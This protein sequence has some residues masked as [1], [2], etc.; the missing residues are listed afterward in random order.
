M[1][2]DAMEKNEKAMPNG[3][4]L[5]VLKKHFGMCF[6]R[7]GSLDLEKLK[8]RLGNQVAI[9]NEGYELKFLGKNYAR[10]LTSLETETVV[11]PDKK[12]NAKPENAKSKNVYISGDNLDALKHLLKSKQG[13]VKCI[14]IDPPYNTGSD[15]FVYNDSFGFKVE[16]L[17]SKLSIS[18]DEAQRILDFTKR[19]SASHSAWLMFMYPR[20]MLAR[21]LLSKEGVIFISLDDN[22]LANCRELCDEIF[23]EQNF[24]ANI[25]VQANKRGQTYK[26]LAKTH[27]YLLVYTRNVNVVLSE[28]D[29]G[30][31]CFDKKD[32]IGEFEERELRNRNP[33]FGRFNRPNLFYPIYV[34]PKKV[35]ECGYCPVSLEKT[36][37]FSVEI[38]PYNSEGGE[39]CWR[40]GKEKFLRYNNPESSME[41]EVVAK[42][43]VTGDFGCYEK[44]RKGTYKAKTIWYNDE[45]I[46]ELAHE[47]DDIWEETGVI[48]EQGSKELG[49]LDMGDAFDF[50]KP[51]Y[52]VKKILSIG[53]GPDDLCVDF[54]S[55]SGTTFESVLALNA[56]QNQHRAIIA[57][58]LPEDLDARYAAASQTQ[59]PKIKK[60]LDFL[61]AVG[62]PHT[63]DQV[64][65]ERIKRAAAKIAEENPLLAK[66][67]DLGFKHYTLKSVEGKT[68]D[69]IEKFDPS[70]NALA[71]TDDILKEFGVETVLT[72]WLVHD[73]YGFGAEPKVIDLDGYKAYW[74]DKHVYLIEPGLSDKGISALFDKFETEGAF[75]PGNVVVF[76]YSFSWTQ[77][78]AL[79]NNL[80]KIAANGTNKHVL[81]DK[82]Y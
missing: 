37:T 39:S 12:H 47:D 42:C 56:S 30:K 50:P 13:Q 3:A 80:L 36:D 11:V 53:S 20:L 76:G 38:L 22:E 27:E 19:G 41:S 77:L 68:L 25:I 33:K 62:R 1:I 69:K 72:T 44:Y 59:K 21:E 31:G 7:D 16:E 26:Q 82:R 81:L 10:L 34:N 67:M 61:D 6:N 73:G 64:G 66:T 74:M 65:L 54:F 71:A 75:N 17:A 60:V 55:G 79:K 14:Y 58:Q 43:K 46:G 49:L 63:L 57:V 8:A 78:E 52:L 51:T 5:E 40:W 45:I 15:G 70:E 2:K 18:E 35:D 23:G 32:S 28:L 24:V 29:K 48:S 9:S 4:D